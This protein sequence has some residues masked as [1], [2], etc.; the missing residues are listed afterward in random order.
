[1]AEISSDPS[2]TAGLFKLMA[3][4]TILAWT[5]RIVGSFETVLAT[6]C[7]CGNLMESKRR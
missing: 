5:T 1:M 7:R 4:L 2:A 6:R 3:R